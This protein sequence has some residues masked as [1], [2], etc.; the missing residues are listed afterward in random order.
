M[1]VVRIF[2]DWLLL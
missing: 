2:M 1:T